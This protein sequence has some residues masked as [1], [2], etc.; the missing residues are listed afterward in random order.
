M[1]LDWMWVWKTGVALMFIGAFIV[2]L[3]YLALKL[4]LE[5]TVAPFIVGLLIMFIGLGIVVWDV[6]SNE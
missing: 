6:F 2:I 3:C 4:G 5:G 1:K